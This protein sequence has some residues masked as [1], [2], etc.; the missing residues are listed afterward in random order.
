MGA[1]DVRPGNCH[2][3]HGAAVNAIPAVALANLAVRDGL[4]LPFGRSEREAVVV[5]KKWRR[6]IWR[7]PAKD[8]DER[9]EKLIAKTTAMCCGDRD[10]GERLAQ[11]AIWSAG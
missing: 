6:I 9:I 11:R 7:Q 10:S 3:S 5:A 4:T 8:E 1:S 2:N